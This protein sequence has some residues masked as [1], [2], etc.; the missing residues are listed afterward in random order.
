M[1]RLGRE[2]DH[3]LRRLGPAAG[4]AVIVRAWPRAVGPE[5]ARNAWPARVSR[6]GV[7]HVHTSSSA[8]AFELGQLAV[9]VLGQLATVLPD[10]VPNAVRFAPGHLPEPLEPPARDR[11]HGPVTPSSEAVEEARRMTAGIGDR[12]LRKTVARAAAL[13][14]E[15]ARSDRSF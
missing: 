11:V 9:T 13:S 15:Q 6:D 10:G 1:E 5:V 7:L 8:W 12:V 2:V 4:M 14:L 3:E